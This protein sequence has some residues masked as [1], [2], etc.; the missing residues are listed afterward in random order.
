MTEKKKYCV[1]EISSDGPQVHHIDDERC[2]YPIP[3]DSVVDILN[4]AVKITLVNFNDRE[5]IIYVSNEDSYLLFPF[6]QLTLKPNKEN[7]IIS[8]Y[9]DREIGYDG[10][11]YVLESGEEDTVH[12]DHVLRFR[13]VTAQYRLKDLEWYMNE[14]YDLW[15]A[16]APY[17]VYR[18]SHEGCPFFISHDSIDENKIAIAWRIEEPMTL[19]KAKDEAMKHY[20]KQMLGSLVLA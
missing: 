2:E 11:T 4:S 10:F 15:E 20:K 1:K 9:P 19:D 18:I 3:L 5:F 14:K 12:I 17:G 7:K 16:K 8:V 13:D 6:N